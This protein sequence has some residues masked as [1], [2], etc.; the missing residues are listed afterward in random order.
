MTYTAENPH[1]DGIAS[2]GARPHHPSTETFTPRPAHTTIGRQQDRRPVV[3][4]LP[5]HSRAAAKMSPHIHISP[6]PVLTAH[7]RS[8][9]A[10]GS[11][12]L[13][14]ANSAPHC[15]TESK[16]AFFRVTQPFCTLPGISPDLTLSPDLQICIV[17]VVSDVPST[18]KSERCSCEK[19]PCTIPQEN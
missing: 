2:P 13:A 11:H 6:E 7:A 15:G 4:K 16:L 9:S 19:T 10:A 5:L 17:T 12:R 18:Y 8:P 1:A 3:S 14:G